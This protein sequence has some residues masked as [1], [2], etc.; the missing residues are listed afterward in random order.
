MSDDFPRCHFY[1][2]PQNVKLKTK[3]AQLTHTLIRI[4]THFNRA[5]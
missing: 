5:N 2:S 1:L 3:P 4:W